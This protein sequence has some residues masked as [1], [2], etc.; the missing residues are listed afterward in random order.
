MIQ[1]NKYHVVASTGLV[2][3][4]V[5]RIQFKTT[6]NR[7]EYFRR[8]IMADPLYLDEFTSNVLE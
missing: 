3:V 1:G 2:T 8:R 5:S 4:E 7:F 6:H